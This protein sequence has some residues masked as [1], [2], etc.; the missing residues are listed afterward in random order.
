LLNCFLAFPAARALRPAGFL[1]ATILEK[2]G[3][4]KYSEEAPTQCLMDWK[5]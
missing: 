2:L 5:T 3:S 4:V 1:G